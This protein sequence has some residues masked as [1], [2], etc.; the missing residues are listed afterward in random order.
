MDKKKID[1]IFLGGTCNEDMWREEIVEPILK[2]RGIP[3][4]NPVVKDWTPECI[5]LEDEA[6]KESDVLLF[7]ITSKMTG[8]YSIAELTFAAV[9]EWQKYTSVIIVED[10]FTEEQLKSLQATTN[11]IK[12]YCLFT[13]CK[14]EEVESRVEALLE[15]I[16]ETKN[17]ETIGTDI[18]EPSKV[19]EEIKKE[20]VDK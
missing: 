8:I 15:I 20:V 4:F 9:K 13:F 5:Q 17:G 12:D 2:E 11:L 10:G 3:F 14:R 18:P 7:V 16:V 1:K 6:K 19:E